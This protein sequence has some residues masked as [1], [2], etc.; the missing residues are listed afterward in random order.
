MQV[1]LGP[2]LERCAN[3]AAA[4][5]ARSNGSQASNGSAPAPA[6]AAPSGADSAALDLTADW[7]TTLSLG[8]QQRLAFAR[9]L[10]A[11]PALVLLDESTSA[12]DLDNEARLYERLVATGAAIV[13]V[14]HRDSLRQFHERQLSLGQGSDGLDWSVADIAAGSAGQRGGAERL[15][16]TAA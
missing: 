3:A 15:Q 11:K 9:A 12:L 10:L 16:A 8:E 13:S 7:A 1:G 5:S 14:G 6:D 4:D 2:L